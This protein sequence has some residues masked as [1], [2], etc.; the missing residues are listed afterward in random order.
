MVA[1]HGARRSAGTALL[2]TAWNACSD[3]PQILLCGGNIGCFECLFSKA[4][5]DLRQQT[6]QFGAGVVEVRLRFDLGQ[7]GP[8]RFANASSH[9]LRVTAV[10]MR[11]RPM[12]HVRLARFGMIGVI[13][14]KLLELGRGLSIGPSA[15]IFVGQIERIV[16][17]A[18]RQIEPQADGCQQQQQQRSAAEQQQWRVP[19]VGHVFASPSASAAEAVEP[20][21]QTTAS[22]RMAV[23]V[24]SSWTSSD[25]TSCS[26]SASVGA[27]STDLGGTAGAVAAGRLRDGVGSRLASPAAG[28]RAVDERV[29][30]GSSTGTRF[31]SGSGCGFRGGVVGSFRGGSSSGASPSSSSSLLSPRRLAAPP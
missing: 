15:I 22:A 21:G 27:G 14:Q 17:G 6:G 24:A 18:T 10:Q 11:Q 19:A 8:H 2:L 20:T 3:R 16:A 29:G 12:R 9:R 7:F 4:V 25:S 23:P 5:G 1:G 26:I 28:R 13:A 31:S 30:G